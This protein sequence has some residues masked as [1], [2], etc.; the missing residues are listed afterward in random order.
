[1][2]KHQFKLSIFLYISAKTSNIQN[3]DQINRYP[4]IDPMCD[5]IPAVY[6]D[7]SR[8]MPFYRFH[9]MSI[10]RM[11][12]PTMARTSQTLTQ[13][14]TPWAMRNVAQ[15]SPTRLRSQKK[16]HVLRDPVGTTPENKVCGQ[17]ILKLLGRRGFPISRGVYRGP[18]FICTSIRAGKDFPGSLP[19]RV[20]FIRPNP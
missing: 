4:Q 10:T 5:G 14:Q 17:S 19:L 3:F 13:N 9:L 15:R 6:F 11:L 8:N 1:M 2:H 18:L 20:P 12:L 7:I 16:I